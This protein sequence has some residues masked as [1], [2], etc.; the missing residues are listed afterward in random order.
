L[1]FGSRAIG[2]RSSAQLTP[3]DGRPGQDVEIP[4]WLD[5]HARYALS[6]TAHA[7]LTGPIVRDRFRYTVATY[8]IPASTLTDMVFTTRFSGGSRRGTLGRN[9]LEHELRRLGVT[10][11]NS[12]PDHHLRQGRTIPA[13]TEE[14]ATRPTSP[15]RHHR[16]L[17][18]HATPATA[19]HARPAGI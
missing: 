8:G 6:V 10:Q 19:Y 15:A 16:R 12:R 11:K 5:D 7:R 17:R 3:A 4:S 9:G 18:H 2:N 1:P 13:G 14:L